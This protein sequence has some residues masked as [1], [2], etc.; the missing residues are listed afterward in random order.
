MLPDGGSVGLQAD[1]P[2]DIVDRYGRL[3][4]YVFRGSVNVNLA[5]VSQG[6]A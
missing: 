5:L 2:L 3:L 4:R 1:P 6:D